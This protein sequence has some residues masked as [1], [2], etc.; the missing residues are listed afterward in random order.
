MSSVSI[1]RSIRWLPDEA[2][3]TTATLVLTSPQRR[4]VDLRIV[5]PVAGLGS[6]VGDG[7]ADVLP[8]SRLDWAIAGASSSSPP[9]PDGHG[10]HVTHSQWRHWIDSTT[11]DADG[12]VDEGD[13][14]TQA[15]G[16]TLETGSMMN[17]ATGRVAPYEEVWDDEVPT[18][19][20]PSP[21]GRGAVNCVVLELDDGERRGRVVRLGRHCQGFVRVGEG[22]ALERW[23]WLHGPGWTRTVRMGDLA[24]P[25]RHVLQDD[26]RGFEVG[27][28]AGTGHDGW[29][30]VE[31]S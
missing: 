31:V 6:P 15:D 24:V 29:K 21:T 18:P 17:P 7:H 14:S 8:L 1:R 27:D 13:M 10:G 2:G 23:E 26:D 3:E 5:K 9:R 12:I 25:C 28:A 20:P 22:I 11:D 19:P 16:S 4:F 30:V